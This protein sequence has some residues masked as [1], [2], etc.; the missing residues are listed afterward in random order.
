[1]NAYAATKLI[2]ERIVSDAAIRGLPSV[3]LRPRAIFGPG[4]TSLF[5]RLLRVNESRGIPI[6]GGGQAQLDL[7][8][9]DNVVDGLVQACAAPE[10][11][12]GRIYNLTN[13]EPVKLI[14]LLQSLFALLELPLRTKFV[15]RPV[16]LAA[17][18]GMEWLYRA[19]PS[20]G[21]EPPFT[22]YTVGLLAFSQT[23]DISEA[24]RSL[25]YEPRI[26]MDEGLRRFAEWWRN[27]R[28]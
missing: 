12:T 7:T 6:I 2:A 23:L 15:S 11:A 13:G 5:P 28:A 1:M 21:Q 17:G 4:D 8:F 22:R 9:M 25:G 20:L 18:Q 14:E 24:R 19:L 10:S 3:I 16:A 27:D 26:R